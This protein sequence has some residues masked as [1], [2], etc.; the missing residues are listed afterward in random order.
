[1][2]FCSFM[3]EKAKSQKIEY[4]FV[5]EKS[6]VSSFNDTTPK[7][8]VI[9]L[10]FPYFLFTRCLYSVFLKNLVKIPTAIYH[11]RDYL[12]ILSKQRVIL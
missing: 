8:S 1:M 12:I 2:L 10:L 9:L 3:Y 4:I 7:S 6:A 11:S 5:D